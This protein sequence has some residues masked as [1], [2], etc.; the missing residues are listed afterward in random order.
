MMKFRSLQMTPPARRSTPM[1]VD[2]CGSWKMETVVEE[3]EREGVE[4]RM[5]EGDGEG[6]KEEKHHERLYYGGNEHCEWKIIIS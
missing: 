2:S 3:K 5:E 6:K 4:E 1:H